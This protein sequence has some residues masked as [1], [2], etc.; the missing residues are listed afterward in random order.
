MKLSALTIIILGVSVSLIALGLGLFGFGDRLPGFLANRKEAGY[1]NEYKAQ[2]ETEA[3]KMSRAVQRVETAREK[4][5]QEAD[6]WQEIV[7]AKTPPASLEEGGINLDVDA[8]D[9]TV[10]AQKFRNNVQ[11]A[12]NR[13]VKVGGVRV[14]QGP[15]VDF[16]SDDARTIVANYFN[17]PA[18]Q[19]PV[20][21]WDFG[22]VTVQ[23]TF[24]QICTNVEGWSQMPN[25]LAVADGLQITGT[26]PVLTGT[27]NVTM[28]AFIRGERV[29][30]KVPDGVAAP[31][32]GGGPA[33]NNPGT[34][35]PGRS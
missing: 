1:Y 25:F 5:Q 26:S 18:L 8:W 19:F 13:Q 14:I 3:S 21:V 28:V 6:T 4:V 15:F 27:Y 10:E 34:S 17:Y 22:T 11:R 23:G 30:P 24:E 12:V 32:A 29:F 33:P 9:L 2:L 16:P 35:G 20:C 7:A 31:A